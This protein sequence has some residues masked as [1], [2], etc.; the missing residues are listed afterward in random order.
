VPGMDRGSG[1]ALGADGAHALV[2]GWFDNHVY[3]VGFEGTGGH[4]KQALEKIETW[5][6][7]RH[8][9]PPEDKSGS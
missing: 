6:H 5:V 4:P 8:Y 2:T 7:H 9:H 3:L 1:I